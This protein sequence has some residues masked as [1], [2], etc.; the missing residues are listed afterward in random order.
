M[1]PASYIFSTHQEIDMIENMSIPLRNSKFMEN[2]PLGQT[3]LKQFGI[4]VKGKVPLYPTIKREFDDE[5]EVNGFG[6]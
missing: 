5:K 6:F 3:S 4:G 1:T 2:R